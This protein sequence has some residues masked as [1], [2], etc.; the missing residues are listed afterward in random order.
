MRRR[1]Y[2]LWEFKNLLKYQKRL[3]RKHKKNHKVI[4]TWMEPLSRF[5]LTFHEIL[6]V[7]G[8]LMLKLFPDFDAILARELPACDAILDLGCGYHSPI[9][10]AHAPRSVGVEIS[11][12]DLEESKRKGIHDQYVLGDITRLEF[13]PQTFDCAVAINVM[14]YLA[15]E[16]GTKLLSRM[17]H[18][19]RKKA[20]VIVPNG[21]P[22]PCGPN[23]GLPHQHQSTWTTR[24]L[25]QLGFQVNGLGGWKALRGKEGTIRYR[26]LLL[27]AWIADMTERVTWYCPR[28]AFQLLA[29][30]RIDDSS[31]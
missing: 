17:Q 12:R 18:W 14:Q 27:W 16:E 2:R 7:V 15:K 24:E 26:P 28:L 29:T 10:T 30:K 5:S 22:P 31:G 13:R 3:Y 11:Q 23:S 6:Q 21:N 20:V 4:Y 19:A 8:P 25:R 9:G 1:G